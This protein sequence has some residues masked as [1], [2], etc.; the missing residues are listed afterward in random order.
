MWVPVDHG[1]R[2]IER[3]GLQGLAFRTY[4]DLYW[5]VLGN[6]GRSFDSIEYYTV[7]TTNLE[8]IGHGCTEQ[9]GDGEMNLFTNA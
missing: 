5:T 9:N 3:L 7:Q 1:L 8:A 2:M 6:I 4:G